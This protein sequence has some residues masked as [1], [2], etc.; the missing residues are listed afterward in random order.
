ME[1]RHSFSEP[2]PIFGLK[3]PTW[4][5]DVFRAGV[6]EPVLTLRVDNNT[7]PPRVRKRK[8]VWKLPDSVESKPNFGS[9]EKRRLL[10]LFKQQK[11]H[12]RK[13]SKRSSSLSDAVEKLDSSAENAAVQPRMK[14]EKEISSSN[15]EKEVVSSSVVDNNSAE[16]TAEEDLDES[17]PPSLSESSVEDSNSDTPPR[18]AESSGGQVETSNDPESSQAPST[19]R[20]TQPQLPLSPLVR[21]SSSTAPPPGFELSSLTLQERPVRPTA[22][23]F[24]VSAFAAADIPTELAKS[25]IDTYYTSI[26]HGQQEELLLYFAPEAQKS[27]SVGGAHAFCDSRQAIMRQINSLHGS[28]FEVRGVVAQPGFMESVVLLVNGLTLPTNSGQTLM[29]SHTLTLV[30]SDQGYQIHNDAMALLTADTPR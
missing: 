2:R 1:D 30:K 23:Y 7:L 25:F 16:K 27:L 21:Q 4:E 3:L 14:K 20:V 24:T 8:V 22:S 9:D 12:R 18:R 10:D 19:V 6:E 5:V 26:T 17:P 11:K 29:F 15:E 28:L 13:F